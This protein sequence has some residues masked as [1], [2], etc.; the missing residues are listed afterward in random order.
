MELTIIEKATE[1]FDIIEG[2]PSGP[3]RSESLLSLQR[4]VA[5]F[6]PQVALTLHGRI[7]NSPGGRSAKFGGGIKT[8]GGSRFNT[9]PPAQV[10]ANPTSATTTSESGAAV[11]ANEQ[12]APDVEQSES[13][14]ELQQD[15][16]A[17]ESQVESLYAKIAKMSPVQIVKTYGESAIEGM[18]AKLGRSVS[19]NKRPE[20]KATFL[21][22]LV[23]QEL[24]K[25]EMAADETA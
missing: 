11:V 4:L 8:E 2:L 25:T 15:A 18:I 16:V 7:S 6:D 9:T 17:V 20:Q 22:N 19:T 21:L 24:G 3:K 12:N 23:R 13:E 1:L 10:F 14:G 5:Q